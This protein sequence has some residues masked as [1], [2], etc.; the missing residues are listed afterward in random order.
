MRVFLS[1]SG[2]FSEKIA[3]EFRKWL[4]SVLQT[5]KPYFSPKDI[6]KGTRWSSE[7]AK[8]LS[9]CS[10]CIIFLTRENLSSNWIMFESGAISKSLDKSKVCPILFDI[11]PTDVQGPLSQFQ[12]TKFGKEEIKKLF[13]TINTSLES[14]RLDD[15]VASSVFEK[16]WPDLEEKIKYIIKEYNESARDKG[17]VRTDRDLI[18]EILLITR[19]IARR[20]EPISFGGHSTARY[21]SSTYKIILSSLSKILANVLLNESEDE[22]V[23][24]IL[25]DLSSSISSR[26]FFSPA[27]RSGI[28][29]DIESAKANICI[30]PPPRRDRNTQADLDEDIPF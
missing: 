27:L 11:D 18:E 12:L 7:I 3:E 14:N 4:P 9:A 5:V 29:A 26:K 8:E 28:L 21:D 17:D 25:D 2:S 1:W 30:L 24:K 20:D 23:T 22:K 6:E 10:V 16:W 19:D 13:D 15:A